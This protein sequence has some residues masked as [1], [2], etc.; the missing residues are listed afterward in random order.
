MCLLGDATKLQDYFL[1][2][3]KVYIAELIIGINTDIEDITGNV[4]NYDEYSNI[5]YEEVNNCIK[6]F[7]GIYDQVPPMYSAK[8]INGQKLLQIAKKGQIVERKSANVYINDIN[9]VDEEYAKQ[10]IDLFDSSLYK[11]KLNKFYLKVN[12]S[13]GTY[14]RTLC[15]DIGKKIGCYACMGNLTRIYNSNFSNKRI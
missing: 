7:K 14:I 5:N 3:N 9:F 11:Y 13:K 10:F 15:K 4:L 12:C 1:Y 6:S 8:K 2:G